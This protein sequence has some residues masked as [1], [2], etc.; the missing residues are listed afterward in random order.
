MKTQFQYLL[1]YL[2][3]LDFDIKKCKVNY[4]KQ[5]KNTFVYLK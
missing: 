3:N 1:K 2:F 5:N 4:K